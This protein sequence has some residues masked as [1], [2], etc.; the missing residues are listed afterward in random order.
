MQKIEHQTE[1]SCVPTL[2]AVRRNLRKKKKNCIRQSNSN[3]KNFNCKYLLL[4]QDGGT[5]EE[6]TNLLPLLPTNNVV[7]APGGAELGAAWQKTEVFL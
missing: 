6:S 7:W 3:S 1:P 2:G 4:C 5:P